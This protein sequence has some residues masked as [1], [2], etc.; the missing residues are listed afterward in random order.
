MGRQR[1]KLIPIF[2]GKST[3]NR[4]GMQPSM[5][6]VRK[7]VFVLENSL[8]SFVVWHNI[9]YGIYFSGRS[10]EFYHSKESD[11]LALVTDPISVSASSLRTNPFLKTVV[12]STNCPQ[13]G[14][15]WHLGILRLS[16]KMV[17]RIGISVASI[18]RAGQ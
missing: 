11:D 1:L 7:K 12:T 10:V 2:A 18:S 16:R 8:I 15:D 6:G 17:L 4:S 13:N 5:L 3:P 9:A 14:E